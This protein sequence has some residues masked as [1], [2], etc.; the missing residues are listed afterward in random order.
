VIRDVPCRIRL[1]KSA[2][3]VVGFYEESAYERLL[4]A[5]DHDARAQ[6][7]ILLGGEA[8]LRLG[9]MLG[10]EWRDVDLARGQLMVQRALYEEGDD[11]PVVTL[12]KGGRPRVVPMTTRLK[13]ALAAHRHLR[14]DRVLYRDD[15]QPA[16]KWWLKGLVDA[17]ERRAG[18]RPGGRVHILRHTF[19]SRLA[20]RNVPLLSIKALAGHES[21][22]TT[23]RY[24]HL[25]PSAPRDQP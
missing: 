7:V 13:A 22:E 5:A 16:S 12:P 19:C 3:P 8:G 17:T 11:G 9:E 14:G 24:M 4:V 10:L 18:L 15:G 21:L 1:L 20:S 6:L 23:Q 2:V 25:A